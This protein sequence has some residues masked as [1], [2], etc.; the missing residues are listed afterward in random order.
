MDPRLPEGWGEGGGGGAGRLGGHTLMAPVLTT[1][2]TSYVFIG[3]R[4]TNRLCPD[5][6]NVAFWHS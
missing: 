4:T 1:K 5:A 2:H 6:A 3:Q